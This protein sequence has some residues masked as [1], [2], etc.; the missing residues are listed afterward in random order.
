MARFQTLFKA[1]RVA[2]LLHPSHFHCLSPPTPTR[3]WEKWCSTMSVTTAEVE[4]AAIED[5]GGE[6]WDTQYC[7]RLQEEIL[8]VRHP[9]RVTASTPSMD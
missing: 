4:R 1:R 7:R 3:L 5:E 6:D 8:S 9:L 2:R